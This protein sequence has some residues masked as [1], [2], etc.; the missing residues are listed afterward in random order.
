MASGM[1]IGKK[2]AATLACLFLF[3]VEKQTFSSV[4][5]IDRLSANDLFVFVESFQS[6]SFGDPALQGL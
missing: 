4:P 1:M 3:E 2:K 6:S 5:E